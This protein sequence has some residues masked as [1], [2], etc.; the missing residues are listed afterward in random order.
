MSVW[1]EDERWDR[2]GA[3]DKGAQP[4]RV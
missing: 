3:P 1:S 4:G 2:V